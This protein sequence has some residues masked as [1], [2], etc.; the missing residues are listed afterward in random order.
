MCRCF[1]NALLIARMIPICYLQYNGSLYVNILIN[2]LLR[3]RSASKSM[4]SD[5]DPHFLLFD[6]RFWSDGTVCTC[7]KTCL[8]LSSIYTHFYACA[9]SVDPDQPAHPC[10]LIWICTGCILVRNNLMNKKVNG[11]GGWSG[12][13]L[14]ALAIKVYL[15]RKGIIWSKRLIN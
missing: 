11:C 13:K 10:R 4:W 5:L 2:P 12:S 8:T 14:F 15:C 1:A 7:N 6:Y 9:T 3:S